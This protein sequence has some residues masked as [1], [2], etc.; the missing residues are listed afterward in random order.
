MPAVE[1]EPGTCR[2]K[3][4][5]PYVLH[6]TYSQRNAAKLETCH[7]C[8]ENMETFTVNQ[9]LEIC[10]KEPDCIINM[11]KASTSSE[12][13][14]PDLTVDPKPVVE[15]QTEPPKNVEKATSARLNMGD[16]KYHYLMVDGSTNVAVPFDAETM[17][18]DSNTWICERL[19]N[20]NGEVAYVCKRMQTKESR[21][22][23]L[24]E[25]QQKSST[26]VAFA[27]SDNKESHSSIASKRTEK[28]SLSSIMVDTRRS[29][30]SF[31]SGKRH[32]SRQKEK[33]KLAFEDQPSVLILRRSMSLPARKG[34]WS[35]TTGM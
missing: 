16:S 27:P 7:K 24:P 35:T 3:I 20:P 33:R 23:I 8:C 12:R 15:V 13:C 4:F 2:C 5:D 30:H 31:F 21:E 6:K 18:I 14:L 25:V 1:L 34:R 26:K 32:Q 22:I 17:S 28:K 29:I 10:Q 19:N 9:L 11:Y